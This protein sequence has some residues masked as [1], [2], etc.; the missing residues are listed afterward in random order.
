MLF[1]LLTVYQVKHFLCDY[2]LQRPFMLRKG[3]TGWAWV[4][5]LISHAGVHAFFTF[6][7]AFC[8]KQHLA[9][10]LALFDFVVHFM[11]DRIKASPSILGRFTP[12]QPYFWWALGADQMAHHLTHYAII[13]V[14]TL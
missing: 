14:L 12:A 8:F 9:L 1:L 6:W 5:P 11:V 3:A 10:Y 7:I 4:A 2:P 13:A